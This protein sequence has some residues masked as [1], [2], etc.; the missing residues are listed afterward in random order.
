MEVEFI[1]EDKT[2]RVKFTMEM[3]IN[4]AMMQLI[5]DNIDTMTDLMAQSGDAMRKQMQSR[6]K[7][8]GE[9]MQ[10]GHHGMGYSHHG[11]GMEQK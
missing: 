3:D 4:P 9:Q 1:S 5:K 7:Q 6:G 8:Q 10:G 11:M 2:G